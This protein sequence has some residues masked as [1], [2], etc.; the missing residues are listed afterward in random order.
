MDCMHDAPLISPENK[1]AASEIVANLPKVVLDLRFQPT[2]QPESPAE[3][4]AEL[5]DYLHTLIDDNVVYAEIDF[6]PQDYSFGTDAATEAAISTVAE[7]ELNA[8][9]LLPGTFAMARQGDVVVGSYLQGEVEPQVAE[10]L[11]Q[12]FVPFSVDV[13][14]A[15]F[16]DVVKAVQNGAIRLRQATQLID[17]FSADL[18]GIHPGNASAWVR[19]RH[20]AVCFA[21]TADENLPDHPLPLLQQ[22]GFTCAVAPAGKGASASAVLRALTETFGYGLEEFFDLTVKAIENSFAS[23]EERQKLLEETILPAYEELSAEFDG[24]V[25]EN[26][27][28]DENESDS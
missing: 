15:E 1:D 16:E 27:D 8:R 20:I 12:N 13:E 4:S 14:D 21:L 7:S 11:R 17:D 2:G 9:L 19:D 24:G 10:Q 26:V 22:L 3:L 18:D 23:E 25:D 5:G 28:A 6:D